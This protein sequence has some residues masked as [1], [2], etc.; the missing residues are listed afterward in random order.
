VALGE[1]RLTRAFAFDV[2][3]PIRKM[4]HSMDA[5]PRKEPGAKP[6]ERGVEALVK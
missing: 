4:D 2:P 6:V 1:Q 5:R 3:R